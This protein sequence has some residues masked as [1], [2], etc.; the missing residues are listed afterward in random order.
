MRSRALGVIIANGQFFAGGWN[1]APK[2]LLVDGAFDVQVIDAKKRQAPGLVPKLMAGT[3]L[4][5][6]QV[7]RRSMNRVI[8]EADREWPVEADGDYLGTTPFEAT[9]VPGALELVV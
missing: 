8:V 5:L 7:W 9:V 1:I 3:H 4:G 6:P 2:A